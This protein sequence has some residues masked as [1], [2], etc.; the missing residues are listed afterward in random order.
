M[1]FLEILH[2]VGNPEILKSV[3]NRF[4]I[5]VPLGDWDLGPKSAYYGIINILPGYGYGLQ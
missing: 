1:D 2:E 4:L 3:R 5:K